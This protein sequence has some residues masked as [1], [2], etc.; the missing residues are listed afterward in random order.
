MSAKNTIDAYAETIGSLITFSSNPH[1]IVIPEYQR[2][3]LWDASRVSD[4][5]KLSDPDNNAFGFIGTMVFV[6]N[7]DGSLEVVDGQ[8]RLLSIVLALCAFRDFLA[9][10]LKESPNEEINRMLDEMKRDVQKDQLFDRK[11]YSNADGKSRILFKR[12]SYEAFKSIYLLG[13]RDY[14]GEDDEIKKELATFRKN[15]ESA[16]RYFQQ[17]YSSPRREVVSL[18]DRRLDKLKGL[19]VN[20]IYIAQPEYAGEVFES[21]NGTGVNLKLSELV[22]NYIYR[23]LSLDTARNKWN[24]IQENCANKDDYIEMI[25]RYDWQSRYEIT[26]EY[27][28]FRSIRT[29]TKPSDV[30]HYAD[31]LLRLSNILSF[32]LEPTVEKFKKLKLTDN[33]NDKNHIIRLAAILRLLDV[34]QFMRLIF[35]LDAVREVVGIKEYVKLLD[36]IVSFQVRAKISATGSNLIDDMYSSLGKSLQRLSDG[37]AEDTISD[38]KADLKVRDEL[39]NR[40]RNL[41]RKLNGDEEFEEAFARFARKKSTKKPLFKYLLAQIENRLQKS[42]L[43]IDV[44]DNRITLEE[45][46]PQTPS[47][48]WSNSDCD[49]E[50]IYK[51]GNATILI[52]KDNKRATNDAIDKKYEVYAGSNLK[53]N[54]QLVD[55]AGR[56]SPTWGKEKVRQRGTSLAENAKEIW[57]L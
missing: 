9:E 2:S 52:D 12:P 20:T 5:L 36:L 29:K 10:F 55:L 6:K 44:R 32:Y 11:S 27:E 25:I 13:E 15:Y 47:L 17:K 51:I 38:N 48:A 50:D 33:S 43:A 54:Q 53:L 41:M 23:N 56:Q 1:T 35:A 46:Y 3:Y 57:K 34:R 42:E 31:R 30:G 7:A 16:R 21:I 8:Q 49:E 37:M 18:L 19:M 28:I 39:F 14:D 4:I 24:F 22:K 26:D 40:M 45:I